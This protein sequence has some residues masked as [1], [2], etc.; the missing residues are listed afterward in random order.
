MEGSRILDGKGSSSAGQP[1]SLPWAC[2]AHLPKL[3]FGPAAVWC[4]F[5]HA[6]SARGLMPHGTRANQ[7]PS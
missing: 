1:S 5:W 6:W 4:N 2:D 7:R 3:K